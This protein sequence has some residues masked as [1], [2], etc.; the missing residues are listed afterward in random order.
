M[1]L[2]EYLHANIVWLIF[3]KLKLYLWDDL[4]FKFEYEIFIILYLVIQIWL[5]NIMIQS[6]Y[7]QYGYV[8]I[9]DYYLLK[10]SIANNIISQD[11][12]LQIKQIVI[13]PEFKALKTNW[14]FFF[15]FL[16]TTVTCLIYS[17]SLPIK[18]DV[19]TAEEA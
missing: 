10:I 15:P 19:F 7:P 8:N 5:W 13:C 1:I 16:G 18:R 14:K 9:L 17:T 12:Q 4:L 11:L 3:Y 6:L 2:S